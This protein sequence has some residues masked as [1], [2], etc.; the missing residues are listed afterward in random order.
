VSVADRGRP[1]ASCSEWHGD[2][3]TGE[4]DRGSILMATVALRELEAELGICLLM[5][6]AADR[7]LP[8][9]CGPSAARSCRWVRGLFRE[10]RGVHRPGDVP[11]PPSPFAFHPPGGGGR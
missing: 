3:T 8:T 6:S 10:P 5:L 4:D 1:E 9:V 11:Q 7:E 2:G